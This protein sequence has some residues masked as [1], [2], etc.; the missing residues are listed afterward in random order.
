MTA[1]K[2]MDVIARLRNCAGQA[3]DAVS[4][5]TQVKM[6]D[7][8]R[9]LHIPKSE[10]PDVWI[11]LPRRKWPKSWSDTEDPVVP[12]ERNLDGHPLA[13]D[14][15]ERDN[16]R[17]FYRNLDGKKYRVG[18]VRLFIGN[19]DRSYRYTC[20]TSKWLENQK[21]LACGRT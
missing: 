20:M 17:N 18:N 6:E 2:V 5:C 1:A 8:P 14:S 19:K 15:Y 11:R 10:C 16:S 21:C 13:A 3:A 4:V 9:L 12:L 7:A